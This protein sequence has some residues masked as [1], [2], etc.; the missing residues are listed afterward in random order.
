MNRALLFLFIAAVLFGVFTV[1]V[2]SL[3]GQTVIGW[4]CP[5]GWNACREVGGFLRE[6]GP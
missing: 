4:L 1:D 3:G 6:I 5:S 2:S